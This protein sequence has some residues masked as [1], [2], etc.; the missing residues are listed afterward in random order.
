MVGEIYIDIYMFFIVINRPPII[1]YKNNVATSVIITRKTTFTAVKTTRYFLVCSG[2]KSLNSLNV[3][4]LASE[5]INVPVP[6][7]VHAE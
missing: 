1:F 4:K 6:P 5:A 2:C 3:I 7:D